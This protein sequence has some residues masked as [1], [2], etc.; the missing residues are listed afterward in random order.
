MG[1]ISLMGFS[2]GLGGRGC[3]FLHSLLAY[4]FLGKGFFGGMLDK[5]ARCIAWRGISRGVFFLLQAS[6]LDGDL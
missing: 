3:R 4:L 1:S 2:L 5:G 6:K